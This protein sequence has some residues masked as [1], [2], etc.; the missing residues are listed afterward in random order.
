LLHGQSIDIQLHNKENKKNPFQY[1]CIE[2]D[3]LF[4]TEKSQD[5]LHL[6]SSPGLVTTLVQSVNADEFLPSNTELIPKLETLCNVRASAF[7][8]RLSPRSSSF[9][10]MLCIRKSSQA[11]V[12]R[13]NASLYLFCVPPITFCGRVGG[14]GVL[15][16][17]IELR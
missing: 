2:T 14:G 16:H 1:H 6:Q 17:L 12:S 8:R 11:D 7:G 5:N 13:H 9:N 4:F 15:F 10:R 3:F